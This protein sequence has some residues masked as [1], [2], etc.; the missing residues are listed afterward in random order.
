MRITAPQPELADAVKWVEKALPSN[1]LYPVMMTMRFRASDGR[2]L[3][4][5]WDGD[6]AVHAEVAA[7]IEEEGL[8]L[9]PGKFLA[10]V[11]GALR[12]CDVTIEC[13]KGQGALTAPGVRVDIRPSD[14]DQWPDLPSAPA[15]AGSVDGPS[16]MAA[17][18][19][20]KPASVKASEREVNALSS[21]GSIRL[22]ASDGELQM[23]TTDRFRV[24]LERVAWT[25][26]TELGDALAVMPTQ[27]IEQVRPFAQ[28]E[29]TLALPVDGMGTAGLSGQ[30]REVVTKLAVPGSFPKV[31]RAI[32]KEFKLS[33]HLDA[34]EL[35]D[36]IRAVSMVNTK[37][38]RP[39]WLRFDGESVTVAARDMDAAEVRIGARLDGDARQ[40]EIPFRASYLTDGLSQI[41]G[42]V[43]IDFNGPKQQALIHD[44]GSYRYIVLPIGD[45]NAASAG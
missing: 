20:I 9:L 1:P 8:A 14:A 36:A 18:S 13:N 32:P 12:K 26:S 39:I 4:S 28:E 10:G 22:A 34:P 31:E 3:L 37:V 25:P 38:F 43:Q 11:L 35:V 41:D 15:V 17:Y 30:G 21:V 40:F 29:L 7:D 44:G 33:A 2:L 23:A 45:T 16:F 6:T 27:V 42:A 19:R 24:G 5:G